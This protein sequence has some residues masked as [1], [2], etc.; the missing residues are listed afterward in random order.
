MGR[1]CTNLIDTFEKMNN[2]F[3]WFVIAVA[4]VIGIGIV[5]YGVRS[6]TSGSKPKKEIV[7]V[8]G[9]TT[10]GVAGEARLT[11]GDKTARDE[12]AAESDTENESNVAKKTSPLDN[13]KYLNVYDGYEITGVVIERGKQPMVYLRKEGESKSYGVG[14]AVGD[15]VLESVHRNHVILKQGKT[16]IH[17]NNIN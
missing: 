11:S 4:V 12:D 1:Y 17:L 7:R 5:I 10:S 13:V 8:Q 6:S 16:I 14:D 2:T 9:D 15:A 3:K